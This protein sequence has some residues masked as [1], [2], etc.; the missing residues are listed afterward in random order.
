MSTNSPHRYPLAIHSWKTSAGSL[1]VQ[2]L[3]SVETIGTFP[4]DYVLSSGVI[5][6]KFIKTGVLHLVE[7]RDPFPPVFCDD[8]GV[9]MEA[10]DP[11]RPGVFT[12]EQIGASDTLSSILANYGTALIVMGFRSSVNMARGPKYFRSRVPSSAEGSVSTRSYSKRSSANQVKS[13]LLLF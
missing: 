11:I 4:L 1:I 6:W 9:I 8:T 2:R 10:N 12:S 13:P 3:H 7:A 5:P